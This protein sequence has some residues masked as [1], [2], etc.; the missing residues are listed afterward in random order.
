MTQLTGSKEGVRGSVGK[1]WFK[2]K[3]RKKASQKEAEPEPGHAWHRGSAGMFGGLRKVSV[4]WEW[5]Y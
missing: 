2:V 1:W 4:S 3:R 5:G